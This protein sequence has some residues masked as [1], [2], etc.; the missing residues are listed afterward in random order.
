[1]LIKY[2]RLV[3]FLLRKGRLAPEIADF[4]EKRHNILAKWTTLFP[5]RQCIDQPK[6]EPAPSVM[7]NLKGQL[8]FVKSSFRSRG[9]HIVLPKSRL[10]YIRNP[11]A[12]ST[13]AGLMMLQNRHPELRG[14]HLTDTEINYLVDAHLHDRIHGEVD[15]YSFFTIVRDP[16]AR[17]V[18]VYQTFFQNRN[19]PFLYNGYLFNIFDPS[20]SFPDFVD[21]IE[22]IPDRLK[23]QHIRPQHCFL[24]YYE[25]KKIPVT[26]L[27]LEDPEALSSFL[28]RHDLQLPLTN[29]SPATDYR[30]WYTQKTFERA[31]AIYR[32]DI[33]Q[34]GYT[35][36]QRTL[37]DFVSGTIS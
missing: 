3:L 19:E 18:S 11:R 17:L 27:R 10:A 28:K 22:K 20:L 21:R 12:A 8:A 31:A 6:P 24:R 29:V 33:Q 32:R 35:N 30:T 25:E 13:A 26:I 36:A 15:H 34:F 23:D 14:V 37:G 2:I 4:N 7:K 16:F 5:D 1:M 9:R